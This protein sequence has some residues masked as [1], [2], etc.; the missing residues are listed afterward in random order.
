MKGILKTAISIITCFI[1]TVLIC[2]CV[3]EP[4][5]PSVEINDDGYWVIN[6]QATDVKARGTDGTDGK[7]GKDGVN[8]KDGI[9]GNDGKTP[10][11]EINADGFW[12]I[13]GITTNVNAEGKT[14]D[15][16]PQGLDFYLRDDGTYAVAIGNAR[17]LSHIEIPTSYKGK[18]VAA[19]AKYGFSADAFGTNLVS[20]TLPDTITEIG[21]FAFR[22]CGLLKTVAFGE[23]LEVIKESAFRNC[24]AL[25]NITL[26]DSTAIIEKDAFYG[27]E[28]L[29]SVTLGKSVRAIGD[30]AFAE[31]N[32]LIEI[33]D[34]SEKIEIEKQ[35]A[36]N[37]FLGY[38][39][40]DVYTQPEAPSKIHIAND[41][42]IFYESA[43]ELLLKFYI[44]KDKDL[45][46]PDGYN[47]LPYKL[48]DNI[49]FNCEISGIII[50]KSVISIGKS[51]FN[52]RVEN[53]YYKGTA[54]DWKNVSV[55]SSN[56]TLPF[57][58]KFYSEEKPTERFSSYWHYK[59]GIPAVW[60]DS[61]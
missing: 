13:N 7:D 29:L 50:S 17:E 6:G 5:T 3:S 1:I 20:I 39:A 30:S 60:V 37:G 22:N 10:T 9:N 46:L 21:P 44:G 43:E 32:K 40:L 16:N 2:S 42:F 31:C 15:E 4:V 52:D 28:N 57:Y 45:T 53:I 51:V 11:V 54:D 59:N 55:D 24:S 18:K 56:E 23:R 48:S 8:G 33:Y 38:N 34:L 35:S 49:F 12:V 19:I 61:D 58:I 25:Q 14:V 26:T 36:E 47:G 27:C 41:G